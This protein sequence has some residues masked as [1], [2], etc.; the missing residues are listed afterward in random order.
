MTLRP[1]KVLSL[2]G[3][4]VV[5]RIWLADDAAHAEEQHRDAFPDEEFHDVYAA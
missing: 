3:D 4:E 2:L 5:G 1:F